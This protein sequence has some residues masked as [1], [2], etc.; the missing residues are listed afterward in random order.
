MN[1]AI[2]VKTMKKGLE[3]PGNP[4]V[5]SPDTEDKVR[6]RIQHV[7]NLL[8]SP[9]TAMVFTA[10]KTQKQ[11]KCALPNERVKNEGL[12]GEKDYQVKALVP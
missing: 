2:V 3:S 7:R 10:S 4:G 9:S 5:A 1:E 12:A 6:R 11:S 8:H